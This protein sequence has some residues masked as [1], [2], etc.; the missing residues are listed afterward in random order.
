VAK[1]NIY[2]QEKTRLAEPMRNY[3]NWIKSMLMYTYLGSSYNKK[4]KI[5][6]IGCGRGGDLMKFYHAKIDTGVCIDIDYE[7]LHNA[8]DGAMSRYNGH[9]KKY[10]AFPKLS[11]VCADFTV[12]LNVESQMGVVQDKT[13]ENRKTLESIFPKTGMKQ[14]DRLNI[15][16]VFHYFLENEKSW[17]NT[18]NNINKCLRDDGYMI[19]TTFDAQRV[20]EVL[21]NEQRITTYY[22]TNGEKKIFM[23]IVRKFPDNKKTGVGL[24]IDVYN[25]L[26]SNEGVYNTEY[27][28]DK[29]FLV[30]E[31]KQ[32]CNMS[33]VD[34]MLF[35]QIFEMNRDNITNIAENMENE[36]TRSFLHSVALFYDQINEFNAE[37]FKITRLNRYYV[38]RKNEK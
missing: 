15:Q 36:K 31:M 7:T 27:L 8:F 12:P 30:N 35:D 33:L 14:F 20:I 16:F 4:M 5:L 26:I 38:F 24:A 10:P 37:C 3:H 18:C 34:T 17:E 11:F 21:S 32:R 6:D 22:T 29:D 25:S 1:E 9:R 28:V 19:L 13:I 23:D 2:Y